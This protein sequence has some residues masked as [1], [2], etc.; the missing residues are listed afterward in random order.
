MKPYGLSNWRTLRSARWRTEDSET[1]FPETHWYSAQ[2]Q[3][4][5]VR[6]QCPSDAQMLA[7]FWAAQSSDSR[8]FRFHGCVNFHPDTLQRLSGEH[9]VVHLQGPHDSRIVAHAC[10][11]PSSQPYVGEAEFALIVD[12]RWQRVGVGMR[13]LR[14]LMRMSMEQSYQVLA[15]DVLASNR[16]MLGMLARPGLCCSLRSNGRDIVRAEIP[17]NG[18]VLRGANPLHESH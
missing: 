4:L 3:S 15:G 17:L 13:L 16:A 9:M 14:H 1:Q 2:G 7:R 11:A 6:E 18:S 5:L 12:D 10:L 8:R